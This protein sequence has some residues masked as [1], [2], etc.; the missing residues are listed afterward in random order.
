MTGDFPSE[1]GSGGL[2]GDFWLSCANRGTRK[3][4]LTPGLKRGSYLVGGSGERSIVCSG[5]G[6]ELVDVPGEAAGGREGRLN[7]WWGE[8]VESGIWR[9]ETSDGGE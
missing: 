8:V 3:R 7:G 4:G 5:L 2:G 1:R 9:R 6:G